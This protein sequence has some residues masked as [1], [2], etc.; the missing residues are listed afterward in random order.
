MP[1]EMIQEIILA[2]GNAHP[3]QRGPGHLVVARF[4]RTNPDTEPEISLGDPRRGE[5]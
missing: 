2:M 3:R 4:P 1:S 5:R